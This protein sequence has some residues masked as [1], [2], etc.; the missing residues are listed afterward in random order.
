MSDDILNRSVADPR[1]ESLLAE[2]AAQDISALSAAD[3][4]QRLAALRAEIS[5]TETALSSRAGA[6]AAAEALFKN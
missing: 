5:R 4:E 1:G 3:L 2:L 6:T